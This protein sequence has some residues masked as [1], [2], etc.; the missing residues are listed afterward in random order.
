MAIRKRAALDEERNTE[1]SALVASSS[2]V[3]ILRMNRF[4]YDKPGYRKDW[5]RGAYDAYDK[6]GEIHFA[7][8]LIGSAV[9][10]ARL[11]IADVDDDGQII[12]ETGNRRVAKISKR[13][14]GG[15]VSREEE[16]RLA[17]TN[18]FLAGEVYLLGRS[19][20]DERGD[21]WHM[22]SVNDFS[23]KGGILHVD[24]DGERVPVR[25]GV[26][27]LRRIWRPHP[28]KRSSAD[29]AMRAILP[30][31]YELL[32]LADYVS[33]QIN[34]R[35]MSGGMVIWP[36]G[37]KMAGSDKTAAEDLTRI[38][39][40]IAS[41]SL[42]ERGTASAAVPIFVEAPESVLGKIQQL[43]FASELSKEAPGLRNELIRRMAL[44]IDM[45]PEQL[46]GMGDTNHWG[47]WYI[48]ESSVKIH[49]EPIL[50]RVC[51]ALNAM[52]VA[53][54]V[55]AMGLDP[56]KFRLT[57]DTSTLTVRPQRLKDT[58]D[59][60]NLGLVS[61]KAVLDAG[62]YLDGDAPDDEELNRRFMRELIL[63]SPQ[64]ID[65]P[66]A[67]A[68]AG[69][70][71]ESFPE[72][73]TE[74]LETVGGN[75]NPP[76]PESTTG[77]HQ[78]PTIPETKSK[79]PVVASA[80]TRDDVAL[81]IADFAAYRTLELAGGR[82][83]TRGN[84]HQFPDVPRCELHTVVDVDQDRIPELVR[85][86]GVGLE[87]LARRN[88]VENPNEFASLVAEYCAALMG[89]RRAHD[90]DLLRAVLARGKK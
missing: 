3:D 83:L 50:D 13:I 29:S 26:D 20:D 40:D 46:L 31:C 53:P 64:M 71:D 63:R 10:R 56:H 34:S 33:T 69:I 82:L 65:Q 74:Q 41:E 84:R 87:E 47:A 75:P 61:S 37:T 16:M 38:V 43:S 60:Y 27:L 39:V 90:H 55:K 1:A 86:A 70:P 25:P 36:S 81:A 68:L 45:A 35:L 67:R 79:E 18:M 59:L 62:A 58:V 28:N 66:A 52:W 21:S 89:A 8:G 49:V 22:V 23:R 54:S 6:I 11:Y 73:A 88:G 12:G 14:L 44:G 7:A 80:A 76:V 19:G 57:H 42:R 2:P 24:V 77:K 30:V 17:G 9:G 32:G 78:L 85:G 48:D 51:A 5:Q 72:P 4:A 15:E